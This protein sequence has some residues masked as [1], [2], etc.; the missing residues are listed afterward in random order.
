MS[1]TVQAQ[2]SALNIAKKRGGQ[3][4]KNKGVYSSTKTPIDFAALED[5]RVFGEKMDILFE[6]VPAGIERRSSIK[7]ESSEIGRKFSTHERE[8][9]QTILKFSRKYCYTAWF[10]VDPLMHGDKYI[11][12]IKA[13]LLD[14]HIVSAEFFSN[15]N[16]L[17]KASIIRHWTD[18]KYHQLKHLFA[19]FKYGASFRFLSKHVFSFKN[20]CIIA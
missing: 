11:D 17:A 7:F 10:T 3:N 16:R 19:P 9:A 14:E 2:V 8:K 15:F 6:K 4:L 20:I 12:C 13:I 1:G 5:L 18:F